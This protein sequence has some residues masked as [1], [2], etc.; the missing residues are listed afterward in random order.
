M[1]TIGIIQCR[2]SSTRLPGKALLDLAGE[3]ILERVINAAKKTKLVDRWY[4][5]TSDQPEDDVIA[6]TALKKS[7]S[8]FRGSLTDVRSRFLAIGQI[9]KAD[10]LVRVTADNP[11]TDPTYIDQLVKWIQTNLDQQY[12]I[13]NPEKVILGTNSEVFRF[14]ALQ[15]VADRQE[16]D[17]IEHVTMGIKKKYALNVLN[18]EN[19]V[20]LSTAPLT[21]DTPEDYARV[22]KFMEGKWTK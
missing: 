19:P 14:S 6:N 3:T 22:N 15:S 12:V 18:P 5:A 20:D 11:C 7:I 8:C 1:N 10:I 21:I 4:V 9:E 17:E 13:M 2:M 16:A